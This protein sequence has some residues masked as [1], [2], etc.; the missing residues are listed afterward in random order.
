MTAEQPPAAHVQEHT[1]RPDTVERTSLRRRAL[2][3]IRDGEDPETVD[4][5]ART[6]GVLIRK[7]LV[8]ATTTTTYELTEFGAQQLKVWDEQQRLDEMVSGQPAAGG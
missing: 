5:T 4:K 2:S 6:L 8:K 7:G 3:A 1:N